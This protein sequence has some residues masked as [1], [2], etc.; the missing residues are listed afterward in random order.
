MHTA[1]ATTCPAF[2]AWPHNEQPGE[3]I[4][5]ESAPIRVAQI[6]EPGIP[7]RPLLMQ[8]S[9]TDDDP[10]PRLHLS[11]YDFDLSAAE[12]ILAELSVLVATMREVRAQQMAATR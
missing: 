11:E 5:H 2:C 1:P 12:T 3:L 4:A 9:T 7:N 8:I 10:K 6:P